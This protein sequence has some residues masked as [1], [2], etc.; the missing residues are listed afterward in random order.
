[1]SNGGRTKGG[2]GF[3]KCWGKW[4]A[5]KEKKGG[6]WIPTFTYTKINS[7]FIKNIDIKY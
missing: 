1:M 3:S 6:K 5:I 2:R 4:L 7:R